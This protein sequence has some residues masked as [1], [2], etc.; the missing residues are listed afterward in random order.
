MSCDSM[1]LHQ[2]LVLT[3]Q[4]HSK[5]TSFTQFANK[6]VSSL[7]LLQKAAVWFKKLSVLQTLHIPQPATMQEWVLALYLKHSVH[8]E[9]C[10]SEILYVVLLPEA[11]KI[12]H[13]NQSLSL[14][15]C[16]FHSQ[17]LLQRIRF[18]NSSVGFL[19]IQSTRTYMK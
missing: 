12:V 10:S 9:L 11:S 18:Q 8:V 6:T 2:D 19:E 1:T 17:M 4:V 7:H 5:H 14:Q 15:A 16:P 3:S 13:S